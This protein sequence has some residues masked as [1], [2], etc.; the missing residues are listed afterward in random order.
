MDE[1]SVTTP[2]G[3]RDEKG[4]GG[5]VLEV[6]SGEVAVSGLSMPHSPGW[7]DG[8]LWVLESGK[9]E[10][11]RAHRTRGLSDCVRFSAY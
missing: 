4:T 8:R 11:F 10:R 5:A 2:G 3:W 7:H 9:G 1:P 6:P